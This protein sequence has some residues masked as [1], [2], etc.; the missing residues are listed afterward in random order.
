[1]LLTLKDVTLVGIDC[2]GE[3]NLLHALRHA[4]RYTSFG[5]IVVII[6]PS[7]KPVYSGYRMVEHPTTTRLDYELLAA[8]LR[9]VQIETD[10]VLYMEA[11]ARLV[12]PTAWD[13]KWLQYDYIG[14]PWPDHYLNGYPMCHKG[15]NVGN[16]GFSLRSAKI[17]RLV[18]EAVKDYADDPWLRYHDALICRTLR[19]WLEAHGI[20]FAPPEDAFRFSCEDTY[21]SG[22]FGF[23]GKLT[24]KMNGFDLTPP[25]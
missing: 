8:T 20:K 4:T 21:Y 9:G 14:A 19:P 23:H 17:Y 11:D 10:F 12:N 24:A 1:M 22:Q 16:G 25:Q 13:P 3:S 7:K 18:W 15:N 5:D 2:F 6:E